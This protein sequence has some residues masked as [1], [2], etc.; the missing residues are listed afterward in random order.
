MVFNFGEWTSSRFFQVHKG[1]EGDPI[2]FI[3]AA[4]A[5]SRGLTEKD[6]FKGFGVPLW[7]PEVNHLA[8][9][10]DTFTFADKKYMIK[11]FE[12]LLLGNW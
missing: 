11:I 8:Y 1:C 12:K 3:I 5:L 2:L 4:E 6:D 7:S 10:D 9:A